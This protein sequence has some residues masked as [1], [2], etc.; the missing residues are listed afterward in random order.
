VV[1]VSPLIFG[2]KL[3]RT[4]SICAIVAIAGMILVSGVIQNADSAGG[5]Q[6]MAG[7][8][9]VQDVAGA[10]GIQDSGA[11]GLQDIAG[12]VG[13]QDFGAWI[14][15]AT[16]SENIKG[17]MFGLAAAL[18]Y[19]AVVIL[20]KKIEGVESYSKTT[21]QLLAAG[22]AMVPYIMIAQEGI[23]TNNAPIGINTVLLLLIVGFVHTGVA[24]VLYFGSMDVLK[25]QSVALLSYIDPVSALIF[26][27]MFLKEGLSGLAI[28]GAVM[29]IGSAV[30]AQRES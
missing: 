19:S 17:I 25:A 14:N 22:F 30:A 16:A 23:N 13:V 15:A 5:L 3:T 11:G 7:A 12:A 21:I 9:R 27:A 26:S 4:K 20:N 2:E 29:I 18:F 10:G 1:L 6:D 28:L 24:Y 8:G